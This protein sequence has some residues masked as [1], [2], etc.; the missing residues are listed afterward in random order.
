M[1]VCFY[2]IHLFVY[3]DLFLYLFIYQ[4]F[5][6]SYYHQGL[7]NNETKK[8]RNKLLKL[9]REEYMK[10]TAFDR[11]AKKRKENMGAM[12]MQSL[13]RGYRSR[14]KIPGNRRKAKGPI[15]LTQEELHAFLCDL[16]SKL[17]F[18]YIKGLTLKIKSKSSRQQQKIENAASFRIQKFFKMLV[19]K[20]KAKLYMAKQKVEK[21]PEATKIVNRA[22]AKFS[23][24]I[25]ERKKI[26]M[27]RNKCCIK[28][29]T[30]IRMF[31]ARRRSVILFFLICS[32]LFCF[33]ICLFVFYCICAL[34]LCCT[35]SIILTIYIY[36]SFR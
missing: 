21:V 1:L 32:H 33:V 24:K 17:N 10:K 29:Q 34:Y 36:P 28:I 14:P 30:R 22:M 25:T 12:K 3:S 16:T 19:A 5:Y 20:K 11:T 7:K 8:N 35:H 9:E 4:S 13:Y 15:I 27:R 18:S 23:S 26:E 6:Y 31:H 2:L